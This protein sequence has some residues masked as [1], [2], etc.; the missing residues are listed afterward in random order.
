[1]NGSIRHGDSFTDVRSALFSSDKRY[2]SATHTRLPVFCLLP[3]ADNRR[4]LSSS[5][6]IRIITHDK[7]LSTAGCKF[8][9]RAVNFVLYLGSC[10]CCL[11]RAGL[12]HAEGKATR[13]LSSSEKPF[14]PHDEVIPSYLCVCLVR[15]CH[16][17]N[18]C[19]FLWLLAKDEVLT[20]LIDS[21]FNS[22]GFGFPDLEF[23]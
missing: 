23:K 4:S 5:W 22:R 11:L 10:H 19:N 2:I 18:C 12:S 13:V 7:Y 3:F 16:P 20:C 6:K 17:L 8:L 21:M 9:S 14:P 1:M 15:G